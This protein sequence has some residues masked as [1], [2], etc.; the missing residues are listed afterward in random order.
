MYNVFST[1]SASGSPR[2]EGSGHGGGPPAKKPRKDEQ[3]TKKSFATISGALAKSDGILKTLFPSESSDA[4]STL[5]REELVALISSSNAQGSE[6]SSTAENDN[7]LQCL[8]PSPEQEF[9]WEESTRNQDPSQKISDDVNA[10]SLSLDSSSSYLGISS[11]SA[12]LRVMAYI[13]PEFRTSTQKP[14]A[15]AAE[16]DSALKT[17]HTPI[18]TNEA[19][20]INAYFTH[21]H[22]VTPIVDEADFRAR[23]TRRHD[24]GSP[25]LALL[26]MVLTLGSIATSEPDEKTHSIFYARAYQHLSLE[27]FGTGHLETVQALGLLGGWYCHYLNQPNMANVIMGAALRMAIA[28]GLH[29]EPVFRETEC[30][31]SGGSTLLETRR[32]VWWCLFCLDSWASFTLGRPSLGRWDPGTITAKLPTELSN[33]DFASV[34]LRASVE[35]CKI[36]DKCRAIASE[37]I[38]DVKMD[39]YPIQQI[40]RNS[41]W[42]LFQGCLIPLLSLFSEPNHKDAEKWHNDVETSLS[43]LKEMSSWSLVVERTREVVSTIYEA[44]KRPISPQDVMPMELGPDFSWDTWY[45]DPFW[46]VTEWASLPGFNGFNYDATEF[47][48]VGFQGTDD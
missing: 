17:S 40:V 48:A 42:F 3:I 11:I 20:L 26:N 15:R 22:C 1:S 44:T 25:W 38:A 21:M 45:T 33:S 5:S 4:L 43:L 34:S 2:R 9:Q 36:V 31:G 24:R 47:N 35:F 37:I 10:L 41:V 23:Y 12:I 39:W 7:A 14:Q 32:R 28:M 6:D 27:S 16:A 30:P 13:S 46:D 29:R 19:I 8:E 18:Q